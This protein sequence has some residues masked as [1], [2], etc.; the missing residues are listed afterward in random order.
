MAAATKICTLVVGLLVLCSTPSTSRPLQRRSS[1]T[2]QSEAQSVPLPTGSGEQNTPVPTELN[3]GNS[4]LE[5]VSRARKNLS[6]YIFSNN[7]H[8]YWQDLQNET[9]WNTTL[10]KS[11]PHSVYVNSSFCKLSAIC[12]YMVTYES[13][14]PTLTSRDDSHM[15]TGYMN[16]TV[17]AFCGIWVSRVVR[18]NNK[19]E[20]FAGLGLSP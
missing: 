16:N 2:G 6:S 13:M 10:C 11:L 15:L 14:M 19:I 8:Q 7:S 17:T 5:L 9:E 4:S 1:E 20:G 3:L 18:N 12:D